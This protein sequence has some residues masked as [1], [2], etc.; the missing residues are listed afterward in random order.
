MMKHVNNGLSK[1]IDMALGVHAARDGKAHKL[2]RRRFFATIGLEAKHHAA[3]FDGSNPAGNIKSVGKAPRGVMKRLDVREHVARVDVHGMP[4]H[5]LDNGDPGAT[6]FVTEVRCGADPIAQIPFV[7]GFVQTGGHRFHVVSG[8]APVRGEAF[9]KDGH[10]AA[11]G[12]QGVVVEGQ[13]PAD[14]GHSVFFGTHRAAVRVT[15]HLA[16]D[17]DRRFVLVPLL[18]NFNE[19][20]VFG[21][22][23][24]V[25]EKRN[26]ELTGQRRHVADIFH[27]HRLPTTGI[28]RNGKHDH[29]HAAQIGGFEEVAQRRDVHVALERVDGL[30]FAAFADH[31]VERLGTV[32]FNVRTGGVEVAVARDDV[33]RLGDRGE[34]DVFGG[35]PL[36]RGDHVGEAGDV[37]D[38][39]FE[40]VVRFGACVGFVAGNHGGPL[41]G[42]HR[43]GSAVGKKVDKYVVSL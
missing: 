26:A 4:T 17:L 19:P 34:E 35:A 38:G 1:E 37:A 36:M 13:K 39:G 41:A 28:I 10:A 3:D 6:K 15:E 9:G 43:S 24:G 18:A 27:T 22:P 40:F 11:P 33:A 23:A 20:A 14:I 29:R 2:H 7:E 12:S 16:G 31:Q 42:R 21:E 32:V 8:H 5:R 25:Q 30:R